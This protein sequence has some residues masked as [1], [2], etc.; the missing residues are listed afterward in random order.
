MVDLE[1]Q[2]DASELSEEHRSKPVV[3]G[4]T[5]RCDNLMKVLSS[6]AVIC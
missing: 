3:K 6:Q 2:N 1:A 4:N 5:Q